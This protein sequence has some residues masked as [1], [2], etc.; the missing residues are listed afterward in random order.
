MAVLWAIIK[1]E[2]LLLWRDKIGLAILFVLPMCLVT[3]ISLTHQQDGN[4]RQLKILVSNQDQGELGKAIVK[5]LKKV[6]NFNVM[7]LSRGRV[8]TVRQARSAVAE[9]KYQALIVI[10]RGLT[11]ESNRYAAN[12]MQKRVVQ[13]IRAR[14]VNVYVDPAMPN[15]LSS[16]IKLTVKTLLTT[17]E[18]ET[19]NRILAKVYRI[20]PKQL[21]TPLV[22]LTLRYPSD[23]DDASKPNSVQQNVPAWSLFGMFFIVIPLAGNMVKERAHG[24]S[25][26][27]GVAPVAKPVQLIGKLIAFIA[28]NMVQLILML[29][30]GV[31]VLPLF[32]LPVLNLYEHLGP[33]LVVG[34]CASF[35]ATGFGLLVGTWVTT[36][37]QATV[38]GPFVI[39]IAAAIGGILV[40]AYLMPSFL[41]TISQL[42]PLNWAQ[43]AFLDIFVR[44]ANLAAV[45]WEMVRLVIFFLVCLVLSSPPFTY[46]IEHR[47]ISG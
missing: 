15:A 9:G 47:R 45:K 29:L 41:Q 32:G 13:T 27:L 31:Y 22:K 37:Q 39:V 17:V 10:P 35:A 46:M 40:P 20:A 6:D 21:N 7:L 3:F 1:K 4:G 25:Q 30:V 44:R 14:M 11:T 33:V 2:W 36:Y 23:H 8:M 5:A 24:V 12:I 28:L 26:R 34:L 18:R 38:L 43:T 16:S 19:I 42:S